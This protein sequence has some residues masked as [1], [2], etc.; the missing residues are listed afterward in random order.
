MAKNVIKKKV[1][2]ACSRK[3]DKKLDN[4]VQIQKKDH[5]ISKPVDNQWKEIAE[6][7][8]NENIGAWK[9]LAKE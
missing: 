7:V 8:L 3:M 2:E 9:T 6:K 5:A 4:Q 1:S